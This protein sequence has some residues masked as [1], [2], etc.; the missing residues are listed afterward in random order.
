[1]NGE[2][3]GTLLLSGIIGVLLGGLV[4]AAVSR[5]AAFKEGNGIAAAIRAELEA[6]L[7]TW[8]RMDWDKA[9]KHHIKTLEDTRHQPTYN[10]VFTFASNPRPF[11]VFDSV[12]HKIWLLGNLSAQVVGVYLLGKAFLTNVGMLWD[13]RERLLTRQ[14]T[15]E[16]ETLIFATQGVD[17]LLQDFRVAAGEAA[18]ALSVREQKRWLWVF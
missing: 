9:I 17:V 13:I 5:F 15:I 1:M 14:I 10:D 11:Q 6:T 18:K 12:C 2:N 3:V 16:R 8:N 4:Q 7:S